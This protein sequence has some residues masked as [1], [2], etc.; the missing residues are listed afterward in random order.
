MRL[1]PRN[2]D[3][4]CGWRAIHG[5]QESRTIGTD[6]PCRRCRDD[7]RD[8]GVAAAD[9]GEADIAIPLDVHFAGRANAGDAAIVR[10]KRQRLGP[11]PRV[12]ESRAARDDGA[13]PIGAD[14][15][16]RRQCGREAHRRSAIRHRRAQ[17][18]ASHA[19]S[20]VADQVTSR[21]MPSMIR[22]PAASA[23]RKQNRV[24][25]EAA[26]RETFDPEIRGTRDRRRS[27][28][29]TRRRWARESSCRSAVPRPPPRPREH[30]H[31]GQD[32]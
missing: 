4:N 3:A 24:Q 7:Q 19:S 10:D 18:D 23:C 2:R 14:D 9:I 16:V 5:V 25:N 17:P 8:G 12:R 28:R 6:A 13:Q 27:R 20:A 22:A 26:Q 11:P 21:R 30:A 32:P 15:D 29:G 1:A 31:V